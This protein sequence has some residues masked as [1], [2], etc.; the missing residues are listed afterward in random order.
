MWS[1]GRTHKPPSDDEVNTMTSRTILVTGDPICDHNYYRGKR[2]TA[3]SSHERGFRPTMTDGGALLL[4]ELISKA[5]EPLTGWRT[6]FG[7]NLKLEDLPQDYHAYSLWEPQ[8]SNPTEKDEKKR[9]EVWRAVEPPL[10]YGQKV[11]EPKDEKEKE[12]FWKKRIASMGTRHDPTEAPNIIVIDDAGLDFRTRSS[13]DRWPFPEKLDEASSPRWTVLKL[14][15]SIGGDLWKTLIGGCNKKLVVIVSAD[16]L[17]RSDVRVSRALSWEATAED[18]RAELAGNPALKPLLLARHSIIT[19]GSDGALWLDNASEPGRDAMLV[20]DAANAEGDWSAVQGL[21]AVFG[22][23]SCFTAAIV[24]E[25]CR[26][27]NQGGEPDFELALGAGLGASR[28][29]RRLGHGRVELKEERG[30]GSAEV[31]DNPS[32][33]FPFEKVVERIHKPTDKF[34]SAPLPAREVVRGKWMML[35]EWQVRARHLGTRPHYDA[36]LAVAVL[37]PD[38]L[39]RFPVA[40]IGGLLTVDRSE[41]ESLRSL[42]H[43]ISNYHSGGV[44]TKPLSIGVFG[45]P[46]AGKSF[47]VKEISKAVFGKDVKVLTFNLSQFSDAGE[48]NGAFHQVRDQVLTGITPVV[49]WDE[50]DSQDYRWLQYLL[51]PMQDGTF[52]D[53]QISHPIGKCVFIFAGAT[54]ATFEQFGPRDPE[55]ISDDELEEI[56]EDRRHEIKRQSQLE[57]QAFVLKKGPDFKSRL[58]GYLNVLGPNRRQICQDIKGGRK[59][60]PDESDLYFPIRRAFF[61]RSQF[62]LEDSDPLR[63][64][65]G[66]LRA[67]LEIPK[68]ESGSRSLEFLC[69]HL[70]QNAPGIPRRSYLPGRHLLNMHVN[71]DAFWELCERD[72]PFQEAANQLARSLHEDWLKGLSKEQRQKNQKAKH[73]DEVDDDTRNANFAQALRIPSVLALVGLHPV[74]GDPLPANDEASVRR[75]LYEHA[76]ILAEAEH[77]HWMVERLLSGWRYARD[78]DDARKLHHL[79]I[80]YHQLPFSER[81][82]D[83]VIIKGRKTAQSV[84]KIPDYIDRLKLV[85]FRIEPIPK[86]AADKLSKGGMSKARAARSR[87]KSSPKRT[88]KG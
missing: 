85:G 8:I 18:V 25:L 17:R 47:G 27:I 54:S 79:L 87:T 23:R 41:I 48:L 42:R 73:W 67:M 62:K 45:P 32:P 1:F 76:E 64:D 14:N 50:F 39:E 49:F 40:R 44:Q 31:R 81:K 83:L 16:Q 6:E 60:L 5:I 46:G 84:A 77:N 59:W 55:D 52:Q 63:I 29:L 37:G 65:R 69:Q 30:D 80:P 22:Y 10:G 82:K 12:A 7:L 71:A 28:E 38:A 3:D 58:A 72:L 70:R 35:D 26:H 68:Y 13:R 57:L 24:H 9:F 61:I 15:G 19:F 36:A 78:R 86:P 56:A 51:A 11:S 75:T 66:I 74:P 33:G 34:V 4:K 2:P 43:I 88:K 21:G 20:F 53:G